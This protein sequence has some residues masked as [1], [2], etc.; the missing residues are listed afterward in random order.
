MPKHEILI[1]ILFFL[2]DRAFLFAHRNCVYQMQTHAR[3]THCIWYKRWKV[4]SQLS[5]LTYALRSFLMDFHVV[6]VFLF[7]SPFLLFFYICPTGCYV[8]VSISFILRFLCFCCVAIRRNSIHPLYA[9]YTCLCECMSVVF[10]HLEIWICIKKNPTI[11]R[12]SFR[13]FEVFFSYFTF[14]LFRLWY[15]YPWCD[16][17]WMACMHTSNWI[18][19]RH[20]WP[21]KPYTFHVWLHIQHFSCIFKDPVP[22]EIK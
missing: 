3:D 18:C 22:C 19:D 15:A 1:S 17:L 2:F 16:F 13:W 8:M 9:H 11:F 14:V 7:L 4:E 20:I 12:N 10:F 5:I 21:H 6:V